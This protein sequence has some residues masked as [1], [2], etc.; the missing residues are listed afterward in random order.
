[1]AF[2][3]VFE[4]KLDA[5]VGDF[6]GIGGKLFLVLQ[7]QEIVPKLRDPFPLFIPADQGRRKP[8]R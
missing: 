8:T 4:E 5:A 3:G 6:H 2:E 7:V 1:M